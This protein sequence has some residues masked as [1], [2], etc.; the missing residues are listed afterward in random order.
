MDNLSDKARKISV[1]QMKNL[2]KP[3]YFKKRKKEIL[4]A[5]N[6]STQAILQGKVSVTKQIETTSQDW[7]K[8]ED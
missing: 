3:V 4:N 6:N 8:I 7:K 5:I 2:Q 1:E